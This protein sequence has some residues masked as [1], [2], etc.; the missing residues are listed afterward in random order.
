MILKCFTNQTVYC[1]AAYRMLKH[2]RLNWFENWFFKK[3]KGKQ[4]KIFTNLKIIHVKKPKGSQM[5][6]EKTNAS[7]NRDKMT[8]NHPHVY[9]VY[10]LS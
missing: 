4:Y 2:G 8:P 7:L 5:K 1:I 10:I 6:G 3:K 9:I